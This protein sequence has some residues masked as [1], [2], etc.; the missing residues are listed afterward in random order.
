MIYDA[1]GKTFFMVSVK[2]IKHSGIISYKQVISHSNSDV[3]LL[4]KVS[5]MAFVEMLYEM[6]IRC[7]YEHKRCFNTTRC[8]KCFC[9]KP[10]SASC[11]IKIKIL[12]V[13]LSATNMG[14]WS[15]PV[16]LGFY[17]KC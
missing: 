11:L 12:K 17:L 3:F 5:D 6:L 1:H 13:D 14:L 9:L 15:L 2:D 16:L 7:F 8:F 4:D 10:L